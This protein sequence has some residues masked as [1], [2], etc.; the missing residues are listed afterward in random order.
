MTQCNHGAMK[1]S[2]CRR[3]RV[4][5]DFSGGSISSNG[6]ALLLRE[7][8]RKLGLTERVARAFGDR[9]QRA[10][11]RHEVVTM[12]RQRAHAVAAGYEDLNDHD[13]LRHD[14]VVQTACERDASLASSSTLCRFE[15]R[16]ERQ[17]A[18]AIHQ[19]L[20]ERIS[21]YHLCIISIYLCTG[22]LGADN[23]GNAERNI[24]R[25]FRNDTKRLEKLVKLDIDMSE[26][27]SAA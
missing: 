5:V 12:V 13:A 27:R 11:V 2:S 24:G 6:G 16:A 22:T 26:A 18:V 3:R 8:D 15:R 25:R 21:C 17:W 20:V 1:F 4:R 14:E 23:G 7:V 9:R 10:K 19:V